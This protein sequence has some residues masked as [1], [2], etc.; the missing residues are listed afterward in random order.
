[1]ISKL[2]RPRYA[3]S[4]LSLHKRPRYNIHMPIE[5]VIIGANCL[6]H[7]LYNSGLVKQESIE[8]HFYLNKHNIDQGRYYTI[9]TSSFAHA[10]LLHLA[11]NCFTLKFVSAHVATAFGNPIFLELHLLGGILGGLCA[12]YYDGRR[13]GRS[14]IGA[15]SSICAHFSFLVCMVPSLSFYMFLIP[16]PIP[17]PYLA[18]AFG[19]YSFYQRRNLTGFISHS[20]HFG[21]LMGGLLFYIYVVMKYSRRS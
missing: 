21:G 15:S 10:N 13:S 17:G 1:M 4:L 20:G 12:Y 7:L 11:A 6:M 8:K 14:T 16:I 19:A 18:L 5:N 2:S 9:Y 3:R